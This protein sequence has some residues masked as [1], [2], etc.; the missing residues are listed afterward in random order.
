[1]ESSSSANSTE[2][3]HVKRCLQKVIDNEYVKISENDAKLGET[4]V[5]FRKIDFLQKLVDRL[6][7]IIRN[8]ADK[9]SELTETVVK[10]LWE[11]N[12]QSD[13][14]QKKFDEYRERNE[15]RISELESV[16]EE[17]REKLKEFVKM[18]NSSEKLTRSIF[19][20]QRT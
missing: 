11:K 19:F 7:T 8:E 4:T 12:L 1:M 5:F 20:M 13:A 9:R 18:L 10:Q 3:S 15:K 14:L 6:P 17:E 16:L 2:D